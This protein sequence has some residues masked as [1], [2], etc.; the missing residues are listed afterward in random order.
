M[1]C[2]TAIPLPYCLSCNWNEVTLGKYHRKPPTEEQKLKTITVH[3]DAVSV[4]MK[5]YRLTL[6]PAEVLG[7]GPVLLSWVLRGH[8]NT[9]QIF[10]WFLH[11]LVPGHGC[12]LSFSISQTVDVNATT[13]SP[14]L[15]YRFFQVSLYLCRCLFYCTFKSSNL[16]LGNHSWSCLVIC[17]L[18]DTTF[19]VTHWKIVAF[20]SVIPCYQFKEVSKGNLQAL[21]CRICGCCWTTLLCSASS[22]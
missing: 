2:M 4:L 14:L 16:P 10:H 7:E 15:C 11:I 1:H 5:P 21:V 22:S 3:P 20:L 12:C 9:Y 18:E 6:P 8:L 19:A 17:S 13:P